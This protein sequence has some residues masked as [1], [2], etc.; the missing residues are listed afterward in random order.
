MTFIIC[1]HTCK[2]RINERPDAGV[3]VRRFWRELHQIIL[4]G[5]PMLVCSFWN[6]WVKV[7]DPVIWLVHHDNHSPWYNIMPWWYSYG[8]IWLEGLRLIPNITIL[9]AYF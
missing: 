2:A 5:W 8:L 1:T 7:W 6:A 3:R 4:I 9:F